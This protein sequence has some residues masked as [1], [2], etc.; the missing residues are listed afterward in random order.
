M[1]EPA[2]PIERPLSGAKDG[3]EP[4]WDQAR[5]DR[6]VLAF[7]FLG[8][9]LRVLRLALDHPLWRDEAYLACNVLGRDYSGLVRPLDFQQVCPLLFLWLEKAVVDVLGFREWTLRLVPTIASI[10]G[11][12]L[13][14]HVAGRLLKGLALL[15]AVAILAVGYTPIRHGGEFKP[16]ASDFLIATAAIG[17][18]VEWLRAPGR[19]RFLWALAAFGPI[20]VG[21]SNPSIF[22]LASVGIA[23]AWPVLATRSVRAI[24]ALAVFGILTA[25]T[26]L[27]L[28]RLVNAPQSA[29]V[30]SWMRIYWAGAF[31]PDS[32]GRWIA[33]LV[34][35]HTS[36]MFAYPAGGD[37]GGSSLTTGLFVA[38]IVAYLRRGSR[39]ILALLLLP[40]GMGLAAAF[41]GKYPYGGS[42]RTMQY[43]APSIILL[44]GLGAAVL[45]S[46][47]PRLVWRDRV[48]AGI[49]AGLF[50][51]G[52]GMIAWD[53]YHPY[54]TTLDRDG[55]DFA[56]R[57]WAEESA[58]AEVVCARTDLRLPL[59]LLVWQGDRAAVYLCHQAIYSPRH[60]AGTPP[61]FDRVS[62]SHP[63][64]L[65]VFGE[66]RGDAEFVKNWIDQQAGRFVLRGRREKVLNKG[67]KRGR[68][69]AEDR[70]IVYDLIPRDD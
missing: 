29:H 48:P 8:V 50:A 17:L 40:F 16:Y 1:A 39:T 4:G 52:L 30:M 69:S 45:L 6:W 19:T 38:G 68:A 59:N 35:V 33:W 20:A 14:R 62:L 49:A 12:F 55:R 66:R 65:V 34:R 64:R 47:L 63:L 27:V 5:I 56:R 32:P 25:A 3:D 43:V 7:L 36:W 28:L 15:M 42:A 51:V 58:G 70:Y 22:V 46:R 54:L 18:A 60:R 37:V 41:A 31:P 44:A 23:L 24:A 53:V 11:L 9:F 61:R 10:A 26:F 13:F 57:F 2:S 21:L 67:L